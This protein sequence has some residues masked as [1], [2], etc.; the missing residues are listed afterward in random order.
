MSGLY[1]NTQRNGKDNDLKKSLWGNAGIRF[2]ACVYLMSV[3]ILFTYHHNQIAKN[4]I[5][6]TQP[7]LKRYASIFFI[8][9]IWLCWFT[10]DLTHGHN[11]RNNMIKICTIQVLH[12]CCL[13]N[14]L[15]EYFFKI[16]IWFTVINRDSQNLW[17]YIKIL[18]DKWKLIK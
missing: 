1:A 14:T 7:I 3:E 18:N 5:T 11:W 2:H 15:Y 13:K 10:L 4:K 16:K 12:L 8:H 9:N 17:V 6:Y